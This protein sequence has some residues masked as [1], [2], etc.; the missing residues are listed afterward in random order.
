[1]NRSS[2]LAFPILLTAML[3]V[4]LTAGWLDTHPQARPTEGAA[5]GVT[6][7]IVMYHHILKEEARHNAYTISPDEFRAD[8]QYLKDSGY[9]PITMEALLRYAQDGIPLPEKPIMITFDDG[10]ESFYAYAYPILQQFDYPAVLAIIGRYADQYT[11]TADHHVRYSHCDWSQL[12]EMVESGL[13]EVQNHSYDLHEND[14]ERHGAKMVQGES[15]EHYA[16]VLQEDIGK[17]QEEIY[18]HLGYYPTTFVYPFGLISAESRPIIQQMGFSAALTCEEKLNHL[19]GDPQELFN[20][21]RFNRPHGVSLQ[22]I[23][24]KAEGAK[25]R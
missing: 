11:D 18:S 15:L 19:T 10:Y 7:P 4:F 9:T 12:Q 24:E 22:T 25:N 1:M 6:L 5:E 8:L 21:H 2:R 13:I 16:Q 14:G 3:A 20:L 17:L 23:L